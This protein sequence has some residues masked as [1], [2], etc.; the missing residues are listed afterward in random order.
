MRMEII[1]SSLYSFGLVSVAAG[2]L[3]P[4]LSV[5]PPGGLLLLA[6]LGLLVIVA[7]GPWRSIAVVARTFSSPQVERL[8]ET[9]VLPP[10]SVFHRILL[11]ENEKHPSPEHRYTLLTLQAV[12]AASATYAT[13]AW[14]FDGAGFLKALL[15]GGLCLGSAEAL[16]YTLIARSWAARRRTIWSLS[17]LDALKREIKNRRPRAFPRYVRNLPALRHSYK[18]SNEL[19]LP[20]MAACFEHADFILFDLTNLPSSKGLQDEFDIVIGLI[21]EKKITFSNVLFI[22]IQG[23]DQAVSSFLK[24]KGFDDCPFVSLNEDG[25]SQTQH[26]AIFHSAFRANQKFLKRTTYC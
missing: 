3:L 11:I 19:W 1:A 9:Q 21:Q 18:A 10:I 6:L 20:A 12:L 2:I 23:E 13:L 7:L 17:D 8:L 5:Y 4:M 24:S 22:C 16:Y 14:I 26:T 15:V 25:L